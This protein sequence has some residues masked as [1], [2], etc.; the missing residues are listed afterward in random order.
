MLTL[1][2]LDN[3]PSDYRWVI[4]NNRT[5]EM[6]TNN[7]ITFTPTSLNE[8]NPYTLYVIK[9]H[10]PGED[11]LDVADVSKK[12]IYENVIQIIDQ[13]GKIINSNNELSSGVYIFV[14]EDPSGV[15]TKKRLVIN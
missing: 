15:Y 5:G 13:N 11:L 6:I 8:K 7:V 12:S 4:Y 2:G 9:R 10:L 14:Y 3:I 1:S